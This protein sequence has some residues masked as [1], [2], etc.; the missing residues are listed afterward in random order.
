ME[1]LQSYLIAFLFCVISFSAF[2]QKGTVRGTVTDGASGEPILF[3]TVLVKETGSGT[4]TDLDGAYSLELT[5]GTYSLEFSYLGYNSQIISDVVITEGEVVLLDAQISEESEM[6]EEVVITARQARNTEVALTTIKRKSTNLLD[7]ISAARFKKI[8]DSNAADAVKRVTGV[9][10]EGGK[11]VFVRG[12]GDR[13]TKTMLNSVDIPGLDPDR[14][15]LQIDIFPTTLLNNMVVYKTSLAELPAD[16]TGGVVNI[17]TKDFPEEKTL[18]V[19]VGLTYNPSMHFNNEF[20]TGDNSSTDWLG[21][22]D[23]SRNF[24]VQADREVIPTPVSGHYDPIVGSF[25]GSFNRNLAASQ[26]SVL[27]DLSVGVTYGDQKSI[28]EDNTLGY[29]VSGAYKN[30]KTFYDDVFF[31]DYQRP[32]ESD[33]FDLIHSNIIEGA[34][35]EQSVLLGGMAGLAYKTKR[36][37]H[38][39]NVMHL[40]NGESKAGQF[41]IDNNSEA[42]SQSGYTAISD[43]LE[44]S[45]RSLTNVL[46]NGK[47]TLGTEGDWIIDWRVS[48]TISSMT[49]PDIRKTAYSFFGGDQLQFAAGAGG[50]PSRIWRFLDEV[51]LVGKVDIAKKYTLF[52]ADAK[53]KFGM[54]QVFK[55]RDYNI[56]SFDTQFFGPQPE[57][58]GD[59]SEVLTDENIFPNGSIYYVSGNNTPNPNEYNSTINN[60]AAYVSNDFNIYKDLK[61]TIGLRMEKYVQRHTGRDVEFANFGTGNNL[62]EDKVLDAVDFFPSVNLIQSVADK[63]NVRVSYSRTIAR[64]SFKELSFAQIIDPITNR[65]FNGGLFQYDDWDGNLGETRINNLDLRWEMFLERGQLLSASLF[66][67]TFDDPIE[68][69]RIPAAQATNEFQPRNVGDGQIIGVEIDFK[70]N[71]DLNLSRTRQMAGQAPYIVNAGLTYT[72]LEN[73]FDVGLYY[74]VKGETLTV[75]GGGLFPDVYSVPFHSLNLSANYSF[76]SDDRIKA[77]LNVQNLLASSRESVFQAFQAED[78]FY[79]RWSPG[80]SIGLGISYKLF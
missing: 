26:T 12:L 54:S 6:I 33:A 75:V 58:T 44:Y 7:G 66:Y 62:V 69:V 39:L 37:K 56:L 57:W 51:N 3:G 35:G 73:P 10:V 47:Y 63:Q 41:F 55:E 67:K 27:P 11:Y 52:G 28:G 42:I 38:R 36:T 17:E 19:S 15:S 79:S 65:I 22:D 53:L 29:I 40:Q 74:N 48:P 24:P 78:Q 72:S 8:G 49:D 18:D 50:N 43:N 25:V 76:G 30:S 2:G 60:L 32:I 34:T 4:D 59:A 16:F 45:E 77:S 21:F 14:N 64:P 31:G 71:L 61:A 46:L 1:K 70:K 23:G 5:P 13:Y 20:L 68:L 9:S 80:M